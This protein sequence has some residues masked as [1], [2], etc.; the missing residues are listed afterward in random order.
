MIQNGRSKVRKHTTG[1]GSVGSRSVGC[2][3]QHTLKEE[4]GRGGGGRGEGGGLGGG[5]EGGRYNTGSSKTRAAAP[6]F[7]S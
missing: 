4:V 2:V 3:R 6:P 7:T 1:F 5:G